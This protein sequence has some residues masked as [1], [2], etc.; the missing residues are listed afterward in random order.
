MCINP[1]KIAD[2]GWVACRECW[3]CRGRKVDDWVGR[4]IAESKTAKASHVVTLTYGEDRSTGGIDHI[5]AAVLT[6][7]DV[8]KYLKYLRVDGYPV[9]YF[10]V[11]EYGSMK[12]RAH[13]HIILYWQG[14]VPEHKLRENFM[15]KHW[16]HG[17]SYWDKGSP[18]A[19][20]YA[21]KYIQ[22]D[23]GDDARQGFGPMPSKQ[24]PLGDAYFRQLATKYVQA[25]LAP[26]SLFYSFTEVRRVPVGTTGKTS[27]TFKD[28]AKPI[29]FMMGGKTAE[30]FCRYFVEQWRATYN[31]EPPQS[32]VI[33][34]YLDK[35]LQAYVEQ[36]SLPRFE[37]RGFVPVP[38]KPPFGG[39]APRFDQYANCYFSDVDGVRLWWS[40]DLEGELQWHEKIR[41]D[42]AK[43]RARQTRLDL[44]V[45]S[46]YLAQSGGL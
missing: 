46:N 4:N 14:A 18:E 8:Q 16:T 17:L 19:I 15:Q 26:Q 28:A 10:A 36:I 39:T 3:Q 11:G 24:P 33:W 20:R 9:R 43:E 21:C 13:W 25:G 12:G 35:N 37:R 38:E 2:V 22:K 7:S 29:Q 31:D 42:P 45:R 27:K 34:A 6:Y 44:A 41:P 30:N 40:Y 23:M 32:P 5:R 1:S